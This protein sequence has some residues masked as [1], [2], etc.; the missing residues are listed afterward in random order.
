VG[1]NTV[2]VYI[3][4]LRRKFGAALIRNIRGVGYLIPQRDAAAEG[5]QGAVD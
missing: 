1:S 2:E 3:H 4:A 5:T